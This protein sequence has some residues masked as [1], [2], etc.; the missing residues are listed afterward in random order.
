MHF[1]RCGFGQR[2]SS[3]K[4]RAACMMVLFAPPSLAPD[5]DASAL[6]VLPM[7]A[8]SCF[9]HFGC[10]RLKRHAQCSL[11]FHQFHMSARAT[12]SSTGIACRAAL[13][14]TPYLSRMFRL[15]LL[16]L[17]GRFRRLLC[18]AG[19]PRRMPISA[20]ARLLLFPTARPTATARLM[21]RFA[22]TAPLLRVPS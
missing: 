10:R 16:E 6:A 21:L 12:P 14:I 20:S 1:C 11:L 19:M 8:A 4:K 15:L 18:Y 22:I 3:S 17:Y 9:R 7:I 2:S 5:G 13:M